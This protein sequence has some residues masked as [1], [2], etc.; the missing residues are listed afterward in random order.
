M[1]FRQVIITVLYCTSASGESSQMS[2]SIA[3]L[4]AVTMQKT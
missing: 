2:V 3:I 1:E 4:R